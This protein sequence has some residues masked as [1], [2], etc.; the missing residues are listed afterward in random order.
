AWSSAPSSRSRS[1]SVTRPTD[2]LTFPF[3]LLTFPSASSLFHMSGLLGS[4]VRSLRHPTQCAGLV[5]RLLI[6]GNPARFGK[7]KEHKIG[8]GIA[9]RSSLPPRVNLIPRIWDPRLPILVFLQAAQARACFKPS[10][11][12]DTDDSEVTT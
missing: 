12:Q 9:V 7:K 8:A 1:L 3:A 2:S 11:T 5:P 4:A 6:N 10:T